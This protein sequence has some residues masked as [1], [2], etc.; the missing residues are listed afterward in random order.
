MLPSEGAPSSFSAHS[1]GAASGFSLDPQ[2]LALALAR[3][4]DEGRTDGSER[5]VRG[6]AE[7]EPEEHEE[8][9]SASPTS[10]FDAASSDAG[11]I[12]KV[13]AED[14]AAATSVASKATTGQ[15]RSSRK[16]QGKQRK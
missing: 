10:T 3:S 8:E 13:T 15:K 2:S 7:N 1:P 11:S 5:P 14:V 16:N 12:V 4:D 6:P 9:R